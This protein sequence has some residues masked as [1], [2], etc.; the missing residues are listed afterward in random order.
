M[1]FV[2]VTSLSRQM[3]RRVK[4]DIQVDIHVAPLQPRLLNL[5]WPSS[6]T[7]VPP[8]RHISGQNDDPRKL[9]RREKGKKIRGKEGGALLLIFSILLRDRLSAAGPPPPLSQSHLSARK[10]KADP[11]RRRR[12]E[13]PLLPLSSLLS[14]TALPIYS[15]ICQRSARVEASKKGDFF[16]ISLTLEHF[17][18]Q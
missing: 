5:G 12:Q 14:P 4:F 18:A 3:L 11:S 6:V 8:L 13:A 1:N 7:L 17:F 10:E 9:G 16:I 2:V 15:I